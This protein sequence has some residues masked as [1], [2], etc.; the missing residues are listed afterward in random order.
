MAPAIACVVETGSPVLEANR[1]HAIAPAATAVRNA[2][3]EAG[4][5]RKPVPENVATSP[6]EA[7]AAMRPPA[8]VQTVPQ[9]T[10]A[11][12][13]VTPLP[14]RV[15]IPLETSLE[16]LVNARTRA[17]TTRPAAASSARKGPRRV[18]G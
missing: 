16:P 1:T 7:N 2:G 11:R 9:M 4:L 14:T 6:C 5:A 3:P 10:A 12:K 15:A 8:T 13:P 18:V 17:R